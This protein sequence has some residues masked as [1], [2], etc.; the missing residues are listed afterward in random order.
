MDVTLDR[1]TRFLPLKELRR[2]AE[3]SSMRVL[4]KA[5]RLS[6]TPVKP[7]EWE[8]ILRLLDRPTQAG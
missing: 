5:N 4:Q 2:H 3:L 1:K 6:I 7:G 8:F